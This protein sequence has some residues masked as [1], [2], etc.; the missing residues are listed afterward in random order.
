VTLRRRKDSPDKIFGKALAQF[1]IHKGL[2]QEELGFQAGVHRTY[3][4]QIER[5]LKSPTLNTIVRIA[6]ALNIPA[7]KLVSAVDRAQI[8]P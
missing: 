2:S 7:E 1:R 8:Q 6:R 3:V 4:S 5:G